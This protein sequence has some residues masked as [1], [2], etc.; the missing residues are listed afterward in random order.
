VQRSLF[1]VEAERPVIAAALDVR[2][3]SGGLSL[4]SSMISLTRYRPE[5]SGKCWQDGGGRKEFLKGSYRSRKFVLTFLKRVSVSRCAQVLD[6]RFVP[7]VGPIML[8]Q[9]WEL[10]LCDQCCSF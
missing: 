3:N 9:F 5:S 1:N 2:S 10:E 8:A 4:L 7:Q 6:Y